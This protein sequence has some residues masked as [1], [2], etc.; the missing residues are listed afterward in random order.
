M[1]LNQTLS[2]VTELY[3]DKDIYL[4]EKWSSLARRLKA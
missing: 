1:E 4:Q 3:N 2:E